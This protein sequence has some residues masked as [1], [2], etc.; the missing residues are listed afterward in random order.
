MTGLIADLRHALRVHAAT[1][2]TSSLA[3]LALA[4]ALAFVAA[5]LALWNDLSLKPHPGFDNGSRLVSVGQSKG[6]RVLPVNLDFIADLRGH[7]SVFDGVAGIMPLNQEARIYGSP[8]LARTELVN[9]DYFSVMRPDIHL[10]RV[11]ELSD[12]HPDAEPVVVLGYEFWQSQY[13]GDPDI[14]GQ[15]LHLLGPEWKTGDGASQTGTE[16]DPRDLYRIVGVMSQ[17]VPGTF[18]RRSGLWLPLE[19]QLASLFHIPDGN[20]GKVASL[21]AVARLADGVGIG[22]ANALLRTGYR[23]ERARELGL[24]EDYRL[25]AVPALVIN[26]GLLKEVLD[27]VR[28]FLAGAV[29]VTLVAA[30]NISLFLLS[31]APARR[32]ELSIRM[33]VG[34][35]RWRLVRQLACE[36]ALLAVTATLIGMLVSTWLAVVLRE[37]S[38]LQQAQWRDVPVY[39]WRVLGSMGAA[40]LVLTV[41]VALA[42]LVGLRDVKLA[43]GSRRISARAGWGQRV[44]GTIQFAVAGMLAAA[45]LAV[46]WHLVALL[47]VDT[48][49]EGDG[50]VWMRADPPEN[51]GRAASWYQLRT[52]RSQRRELIET[53]PEV[54]QVAFGN[55]V[56]GRP[57]QFAIPLPADSARGS[58]LLASLVSADHAYPEVLDMELLRGRFLHPWESDG[59]LVNET[60]A[61]EYWGHLDV[62]GELISHPPYLGNGGS[63]AEVV[64]VVR[65]MKFLH[66]AEGAMPMIFAPGLPTGAHDTI[67]VRTSMH[68]EALLAALE[69]IIRRDGLDIRFREASALSEVWAERLSADHART[70]LTAASAGLVVLLSGLGFYGTQRYL[71]AAGRREYAIR[72]AVGAGPRAIGHLVIRRGLE[73]GLPGVLLGGLLA[74]VLVAWMRNEQVVAFVMPLPVALVTGAGLLALVMISVVGPMRQARR[75]RLAQVL[76]EE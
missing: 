16:P 20:Y 47:E 22:S 73:L 62:G 61:R 11:L 12:H 9:R 58:E 66:P 26:T 18:D 7:T 67:L 60:L 75:K 38:F 35:G 51:V 43:S 74:F 3:V 13:G 64:G 76:R 70:W 8:V 46:G 56:P 44:A 41:V 17:R 53:L 6:E 2:L 25:Q 72:A 33:A 34:A 28:L 65:D 15:T 24:R 32:R 31:R 5:F 10:G 23:G 36:A 50:V 49:F 19:N 48:G 21:Y 4:V 69:S 71:V 1:P 40:V 68:P 54:R 45:A 57:Q 27:Q 55:P 59:I 42:P 52:L 14:L 29:L 63:G 39:D 37:L 30:C